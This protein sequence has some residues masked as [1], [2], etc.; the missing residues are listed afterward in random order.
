MIW[1]HVGRKNPFFIVEKSKTTSISMCMIRKY[2][3]WVDMITSLQHGML[4]SHVEQDTILDEVISRDAYIW[5]WNKL[6]YFWKDFIA[7]LCTLNFW[8]LSLC[9][10]A[11]R[12]RFSHIFQLKISYPWHSF[13]LIRCSWS[14]V[15]TL[16]TLVYDAEA[17]LF[18]PLDNLPQYHLVA[19]YRALF[20]AL[21]WLSRKFLLNYFS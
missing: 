12:K 6:I 16:W 17:Q 9:T 5:E 10:C 3:S 21:L 19:W 8:L 11:Y 4:G 20:W 2:S 7:D 15:Q 13:Y 14:L 18:S 1:E